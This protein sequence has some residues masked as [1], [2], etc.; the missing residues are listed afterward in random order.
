V[1]LTISMT[2][3]AKDQ[4]LHHSSVD[5]GGLLRALSNAGVALVVLSALAWRRTMSSKT[6]GRREDGTAHNQRTET[7]GTPPSFRS[8]A[9]IFFEV[10][11]RVIISSPFPLPRGA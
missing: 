1:K 3:L 4:A 10:V 11:S 6:E 8:Q 5:L 2:H 7:F 9:R